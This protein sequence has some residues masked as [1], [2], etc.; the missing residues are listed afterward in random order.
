MNWFGDEDSKRHL[1]VGVGDDDQL[2]IGVE[3]Q[4]RRVTFIPRQHGMQL[5]RLQVN[6]D[7]LALVV[8]HNSEAAV[9][10]C[11]HQMDRVF[12]LEFLLGSERVHCFDFAGR[13]EI[14]QLHRLLG[15]DQQQLV[16]THKQHPVA[17][18]HFP[19]NE[20]LLQ[21][22]RSVRLSTV[23]AKNANTSESLI[24]PME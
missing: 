1:V 15:S 17:A 8:G 19:R 20:P 14:Q 11:I 7:D 10:R 24:W 4:R 12:E 16:A 23:S 3:S 21:L 6:H 5:E 13:C 9:R 22:R 18:S 2:G